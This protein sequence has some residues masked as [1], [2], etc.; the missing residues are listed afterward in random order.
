MSE[1]DQRRGF[2]RKTWDMLSPLFTVARNQGFQAGWR[3]ELA[4]MTVF[5]RDGG[6]LGC[7][8]RKAI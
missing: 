4:N 7:I 2:Y 6:I 8:F 5:H 3:Y 1:L